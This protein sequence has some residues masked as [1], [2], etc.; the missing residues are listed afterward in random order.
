MLR[1]GINNSGGFGFYASKY[2]ESSD[3]IYEIVE[4]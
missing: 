4:V 3:S 2:V 1:D